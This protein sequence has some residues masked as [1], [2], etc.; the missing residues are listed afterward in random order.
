MTAIFFRVRVMAMKTD[1][2]ISHIRAWMNRRRV[3]AATLAERA[4]LNPKTVQGIKRDNWQPNVRTLRAI[5]S[6][7][8]TIDNEE[9]MS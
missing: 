7:M 6:A 3:S 1:D 2:I 4:E 8:A 5:E 9:G